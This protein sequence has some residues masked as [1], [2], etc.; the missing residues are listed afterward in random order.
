MSLTKCI[1]D[2]SVI[3]KL[4]VL[5]FLK[6]EHQRYGMGMQAMRSHPQSLN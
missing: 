2:F 5:I 6:F 4:S 1:L 3:R